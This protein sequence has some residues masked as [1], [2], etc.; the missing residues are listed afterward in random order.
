MRLPMTRKII[1]LALPLLLF[2]LLVTPY[3]YINSTYLVQR[4]G[5]GCPQI[6][7]S[8]EIVENNFN[9]NT[10]TAIV[11]S[12]VALIVTFIGI[13]LSRLLSSKWM[14]ALYIVLLFCTSLAISQSLIQS[15]MW[16]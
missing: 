9:A 5:C 8:G 3:Q 6:N 11:W 4:F 1:L 12:C 15:M 2:V 10:V 16:N 7:A 14:R 13:A